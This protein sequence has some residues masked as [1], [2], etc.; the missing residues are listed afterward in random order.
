MIRTLYHGSNRIIESPVFGYGNPHNDYGM[1]FYC[2]TNKSLA[3]EWAVRK[4]SDGFVNVYTLRDDRLRILDLTKGKNHEVVLWVSILM[5]HR[6]I[7]EELRALYK[8][9]LDYLFHNYAVQMD[10]YD[11]VIGYRADDA[12]YRFP[13]A[14]V[15]GEL[16]IE[17][18]E[19]IFHADAFG[20]QYVLV[21]KRAFK[22]VKFVRYEEVKEE[23]K[24]SYYAR[25]HKA[26]DLFQ[27]TLLEERYEK[28]TRLRDLVLSNE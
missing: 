2:C 15:R 1:G 12:Y 10:A 26:N 22:D 8:R 14:F 9:E 21:S 25:V 18:L 28:G 16:T 19:R 23:Q 6:S 5:Q 7:A 11:V 4:N 24:I 27:K 13:E 20:K 3:R 17:S